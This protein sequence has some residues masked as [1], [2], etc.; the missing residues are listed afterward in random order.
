MT[1]TKIRF[2]FTFHHGDTAAILPAITAGAAILRITVF[3]PYHNNFCVD[4]VIYCYSSVVRSPMD[5]RSFSS[6]RHARICVGALA[7]GS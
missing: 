5:A 4:G 3:A 1:D 6:N 2:T 7:T